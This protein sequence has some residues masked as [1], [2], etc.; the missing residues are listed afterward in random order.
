MKPFLF[1][2]LLRDVSAWN[3]LLFEK[4]ICVQSSIEF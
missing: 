3:L 1:Q 2:G 4:V